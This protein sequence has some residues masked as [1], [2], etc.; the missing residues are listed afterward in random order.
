MNEGGWIPEE[1]RYHCRVCE[2]SIQSFLEEEEDW[3]S[4]LI[5]AP[6]QA[7]HRENQHYRKV[8]WD[9]D[10][11]NKVYTSNHPNQ[12]RVFHKLF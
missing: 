1:N 12:I 5:S 4:H 7:I 8:L 11:L 6:H 9:L 2:V 3:I 10:R